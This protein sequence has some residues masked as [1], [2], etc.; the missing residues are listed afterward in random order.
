MFI[1]A[2]CGFGL[3]MAWDSPERDERGRMSIERMVLEVA[4]NIVARAR[5]PSWTYKLGIEK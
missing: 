1:I 4:T 5:L 3:P 2:I